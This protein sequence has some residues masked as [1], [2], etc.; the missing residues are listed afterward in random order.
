MHIAKL[1]D[2]IACP[3]WIAAHANERLDGVC[4]RWLRREPQLGIDAQRFAPP[5]VMQTMRDR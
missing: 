5:Q 3:E 4:M 2:A 1:G